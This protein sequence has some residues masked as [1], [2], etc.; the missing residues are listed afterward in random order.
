MSEKEYPPTLGSFPLKYANRKL[1]HNQWPQPNK[2][3]NSAN[4]RIVLD[5]T[6]TGLE[7]VPGYFQYRMM[8]PPGHK[9]VLPFTLMSFKEEEG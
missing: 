1:Y 5:R 6:D 9:P 3:L 4:H 8:G 2:V 7:A